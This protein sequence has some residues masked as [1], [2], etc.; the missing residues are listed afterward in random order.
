MRFENAQL[1]RILRSPYETICSWVGTKRDFQR[2]KDANFS[3]W[4]VHY[5]ESRE[6]NETDLVEIGFDE[7]GPRINLKEPKNSA[8]E[9][10]E[11]KL[12]TIEGEQASSRKLSVYSLDDILSRKN[13]RSWLEMHNACDP[14]VGIVEH[15]EELGGAKLGAK[16][17]LGRQKET[18]KKAKARGVSTTLKNEFRLEIE[19][20]DFTHPISLEYFF[21]FWGLKF[22]RC[23]FRGAMS[24]EKLKSRNAVSFEDCI[25]DGDVSFRDAC[26]YSSFD[27][28]NCYFG[29]NCDFSNLYVSGRFTLSDTV[30][31]D[32]LFGPAMSLQATC[33]VERNLFF[34]N[35]VNLDE[36]LVGVDLTFRKNYFDKDLWMNDAEFQRGAYFSH[37]LFSGECL[38]TSSKYQ[39]SVL[40]MYNTHIG[41]FDVSDADLSRSMSMAGTSFYNLPPNLLGTELPDDF[42]WAPRGYWA[43]PSELNA[44][45]RLTAF[46]RYSA[47][48]RKH[49]SRGD[50]ADQH[51]F[52]RKELACRMLD[53]E[54][55]ERK[56]LRVFSVLS[57]FGWS[58]TRPLIGMASNVAFHTFVFRAYFSTFSE[59]FSLSLANQFSFLGFNR[60]LADEALNGLEGSS[61][62]L[63]VGL[64]IFF[65][66][67]LWGLFLLSI[68]NRVRMK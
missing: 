67:A 33:Y 29:G 50:F 17:L 15:L 6:A 41:D 2:S 10:Q 5:L 26:I 14:A 11:Y 22:K 9:L 37:N 43:D 65:G 57:N 54:F 55:F 51:F 60:F 58:M 19:D 8:Q 7:D 36:T 64:Q 46:P 61:G 13:A 39:S 31:S 18:L 30:F 1:R 35:N 42:G 20:Q 66:Y 47:L 38:L 45:T 16:E 21:L 4:W 28:K 3:N 62:E 12:L 56:I 44:K 49:S 25:F 48:R 32:G 34:G 24:L 63:F 59:S 53:G 52:Y 27:M 68:A 23:R 40:W